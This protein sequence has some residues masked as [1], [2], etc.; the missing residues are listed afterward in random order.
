MMSSGM[1]L[2]ITMS[3]GLCRGCFHQSSSVGVVGC[4]GFGGK[5]RGVCL[6][7]SWIDFTFLLQQMVSL[8]LATLTFIDE[9]PPGSDPVN[10]FARLEFPTGEGM[11]LSIILLLLVSYRIVEPD[12]GSVPFVV[13]FL[14]IFSCSGMA[15]N[16]SATFSPH[17]VC[18]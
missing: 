1:S 15:M 5:V 17:I 9:C 12:G 3:R 18:L 10:L 14:L 13:F 11:A 6:S 4:T 7:S 16:A 8:N 2:W